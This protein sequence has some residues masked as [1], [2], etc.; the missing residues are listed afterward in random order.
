MIQYNSGYCEY[1]PKTKN[2]SEMWRILISRKGSWY[3]WYAIIVDEDG[4]LDLYPRNSQQGKTRSGDLTA[5]GAQKHRLI[6]L[7]LQREFLFE[8]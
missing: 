6:R 7:L 5:T 3:S 8:P 2:S 1:F 4:K